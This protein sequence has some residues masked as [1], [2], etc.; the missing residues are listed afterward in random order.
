MF[1]LTF[2]R[3]H[4][5]GNGARGIRSG[6][7]RNAADSSTVN[8]VISRREGK[9]K[10]MIIHNIACVWSCTYRNSTVSRE[11]TVSNP[12]VNPDDETALAIAATPIPS[13]ATVREIHRKV[14]EAEALL[15]SG[16]VVTT[17]NYTTSS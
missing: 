3:L 9:C 10:I 7:I 13:P 15:H 2:T 11:K 16:Q 5:S 17:L 6:R 12:F 1:T 8:S 14:M 4:R